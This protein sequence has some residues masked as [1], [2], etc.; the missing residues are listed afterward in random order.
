MST[1]WLAG[2]KEY[3]SL[4]ELG[5]RRIVAKL[6][7]GAR[8]AALHASDI[9][10]YDSPGGPRVAFTVFPH[11][12]LDGS[13]IR[14]TASLVGRREVTNSGG[15]VQIRYIISTQ[16][17]LGRES[18]ITEISL[19][20]RTRMRYPMLLGRATLGDRFLINPGMSYLTKKRKGKTR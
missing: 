19:T 17:V 7:T 18:W 15:I 10:V 3:V 4:P 1:P 16:L 5:L 11:R 12:G 9:L 8:S 6:D 2:W 14:C 20:D 13:G